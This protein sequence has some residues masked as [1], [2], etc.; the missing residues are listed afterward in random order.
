[1]SYLFDHAW[2]RERERLAQ[3]EAAFDPITIEC[4]EAIGAGGGWR[5]L[6]VGA[7][8]GSIA[9]WLCDRVGPD[10][11]VVATDL[12]TRFLEAIEAP[13][14]D[15]RRHDISRDPLEAAA[16]DLVH[17]RK[18]LEHLPDPAPALKAMYA[19]LAPGGWLLVEDAD[20]VSLRH[21]SGLAPEGFERGYSAFMAAMRDGGYD[22]ALGIRLGDE[23]RGLGLGDV[24]VR[25]WAGE[26]GGAPGPS[27]FL[28]TFERLRERVVELGLL[29]RDEVE[30]FLADLRRPGFRAITAV[31]FAAWGRRPE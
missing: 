25:G 21:V 8:G 11:R 22:P 20:L 14:L 26:W 10:G 2:K 27:V 16:F 18:V 9:A 19:A 3:M 6:E 13:N 23:L 24:R 28:L 17:A 15:P 1:M 4:L 12:D 30:R 7:G 29:G 31:H 5:C